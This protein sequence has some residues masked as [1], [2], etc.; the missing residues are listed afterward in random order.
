MLKK[1]IDSNQRL[2]RKFDKILPVKYRVDGNGDYITSLVPKYLKNDLIIYDVGGGKN[3]FLS[4]ERKKPIHATVIGVD[5]DHKELLKAPEG[6]YDKI[7]C[8]DITKFKGNHD[9][10][11]IMCQAVLEHVKDVEQAFVAF[12]SMLK[13]GGLLLIFVP[14]KNAIFARINLVLPET[15]KK[16]ILS[17]LYSKNIEDRGFSSYYDRCTPQEMKKLACQNNLSLI[18]SHFY[19]ISSYFSFFF[20]AYIFW[21]LW[22]VLFHFFVEEQAAESFSLVLKNGVENSS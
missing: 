11:I 14:S 5:I 13:P 20:P 3:P 15:T 9:A 1:F 8:T 4:P 10:D 2:S 19:Y 21:R 22:V 18:E 6:A 17:I 7:I 16:K 12:S